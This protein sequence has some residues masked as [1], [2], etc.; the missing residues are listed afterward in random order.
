ML[1]GAPERRSLL[2]SEPLIDE[3]KTGPL[4]TALMSVTMLVDAQIEAN[5]G[6]ISKEKQRLLVSK[7]GRIVLG[8]FKL[9]T[10]GGEPT[11]SG[12]YVTK[13]F[14][15]IVRL[16]P[17]DPYARAQTAPF[18]ACTAM[19]TYGHSWNDAHGTHDTVEIAL[20][21]RGRRF[22]SERAI[23]RDIAWLA[24]ARR[25]REIRYGLRPF[26]SKTAAKQLGDRVVARPGASPVLECA[27]DGDQSVSPEAV[28]TRESG[29]GDEC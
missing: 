4:P 7:D 12:V 21:P 13:P 26:S 25:F 16:R 28:G 27:V 14:T 8:C 11:A 22:L 6:N 17:W 10:V 1:R 15:T 3:E 19:G 18:D 24:R 23:A 20:T 29:A 9:V 5:F 2:I